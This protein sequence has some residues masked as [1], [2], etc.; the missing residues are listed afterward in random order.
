[1]AHAIHRKSP[2]AGSRFLQINCAAI[3]EELIESELFGHERGAFTGA[4]SRREGKFELA[5][6]GTLLLDEIGDMSATVQAK[7]LRVLEEGTFERVGGTKT[8]SVDVRILAAT[9][10]DL[11]RG[12]AAGRFREDLFFRLAVVPIRVPPLRE[13]RDD[14]P[15]LVDHFSRSTASGRSARAW[16]WARTCWSCSR[17]TSGRATCASCATRSSAWPSSRTATD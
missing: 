16:R 10:M 7:V 2:R 5:D 9:N 15:L 14:I 11:E 8:L 3:P 17:A 12:V 6:G 13:R 1:V 4:T